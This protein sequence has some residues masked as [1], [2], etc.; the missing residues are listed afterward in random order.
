[1]T[2]TTT[3]GSGAPG[4]ARRAL[5]ALTAYAGV[6]ALGASLAVAA[7]PASADETVPLEGGSA[8]WGVKQSFRNYI[9]GPIAHGGYEASDGATVLADGTVDFPTAGGSVSKEDASGEVDFAGTVVFSGHDYGRGPVL[10]VR[11]SDPRVVFDGDA[12]TVYA[13]VTS[14]E[15]GGADPN[16]P[17]GDLVGYG[18][19]A[20]AELTGAELTVE[21]EEI[22]FASAA[23]TLHADAVEPFASFYAAGSPMDPLSFTAGIADVTDPGGP[24][25]APRVTVAPDSGL[26]P[27]GDTVTLEGAGFRPGQGVYAAL[28]ALPRSA[29][30]FPAH[31]TGAVWL[32]GATAPGED[33]AFSTEV[34]VT[35][36]YDK[37]GTTYD[38]VESQCYV[39]VFNDHTDIANRDQDVWT[40]VSFASG[41]E[42][43][44]EP[45]DPTEEPTDPVDPTDPDGPL[46]VHNGR[47]DWGVKE[48]FRDYI[49]GNIA[50]GEISTRNGATT[51]EDGTYAFTN[52]SG[53]VD[54]SASTADIG[55]EGTVVFEGH[56]YDG[57]DPLLHMTVSDPRV[58][59]EDGAGVLYA[60]VVS[61]SL[62]GEE[63]VSY[64]DVAF[65]DL[66]LSGVEYELADGVLSWD[67]IPASL[68]AEGVPAFADFY[69]EGAA[70]DPV[71]L[72]VSV[73]EAVTV[74]GG[75]DGAGGTPGGPGDG[76][77]DGGGDDPGLPNTG[78]AL[79][80]LLA[81]AAVAVAAGGT[82]VYAARRRRAPVPEDAA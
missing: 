42:P 21:G 48:S 53:E 76:G 60:D 40:P 37:D 9:S 74:P 44:E 47:A 33:G 4:R 81:A 23:A 72:T 61:K 66:D 26:D 43:T 38:C 28:T 51:N 49:T 6:A 2:T 54:L 24:D 82:A 16:L 77:G 41:E 13:D 70:L 19:V 35:G 11:V 68:T 78:A 22:A 34:A 71:A 50:H 75:G 12:A 69:A 52:G 65:A 10:E 57:A 18:E 45:T 39:A 56:V 79:T 3:G 1:M 5:R 62:A 46:T 8:A 80:G 59:I 32:R 63:L 27:E 15:F 30:S 20:V 67:P 58:E 55:F 73:D 25:P 64:E 31:Y 7:A 14:R 36:S 29:D 17:P